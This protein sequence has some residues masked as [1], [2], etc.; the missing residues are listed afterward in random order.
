MN[1]FS[2]PCD[3]CRGEIFLP[4]APPRFIHATHERTPEG[5]AD[6]SIA[7]HGDITSTEEYDRWVAS[8][9]PLDITLH[10]ECWESFWAAHP[11]RLN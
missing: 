6:L 2:I 5:H 7:G 11:V 4:G 8:G 10:V 3:H 1:H 9:Q